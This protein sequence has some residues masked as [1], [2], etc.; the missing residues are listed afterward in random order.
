[1]VGLLLLLI[2]K[3]S[4]QRPSVKKCTLKIFANFTGKHLC[5]SL[6]SIK[7][8]ARG[9]AT[10][11]KKDFN[12]G[13]FFSEISTDISKKNFWTSASVSSLAILFALHEKDTANEV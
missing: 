7:L 4:H 13:V 6:F 5:L 1:M 11:L 2:L 3:C 8:Q 9:P 12:V 10:F